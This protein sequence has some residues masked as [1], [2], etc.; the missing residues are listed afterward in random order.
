MC[1]NIFTWS[2]CI[3]CWAWQRRWRRWGRFALFAAIA[4]HQLGTHRFTVQFG[5]TFYK[6]S[7]F[8]G[9]VGKVLGQVG[10]N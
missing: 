6:F 9:F 5:K 4:G 1:H 2:W 7:R 8:S 10:L 3:I